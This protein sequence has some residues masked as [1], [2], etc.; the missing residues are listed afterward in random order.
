MTAQWEATCASGVT[1][2][3]VTLS[4]NGVKN[5][6]YTGSVKGAFLV[7][8]G[9]YKLEVWGGQGGLA[10]VS[11]NKTVYRG[12]YGGYSTGV[13]YA[14]S[15]D[16]IYIVVGGQASQTCAT[17]GTSNCSGGYNGG[18]SGNRSCSTAGC[19]TWYSTNPSGGGGAT[20]IATASG[21]LRYLSGNTNS[22]L[23]VASGG[24]GS[25]GGGRRR[26]LLPTGGKQKKQNHR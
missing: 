1:C 25:S 17:A 20:H 10:H 2:E 13:Y 3:S 7:N 26:L 15:N 6:D 21:E 16:L 19:S 24:G 23:I 8:S 22:V 4:T 18:G 14:N 11:T 12:G 9:Y 5:Y